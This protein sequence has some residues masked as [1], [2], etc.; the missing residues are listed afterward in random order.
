L[1]GESPPAIIAG[2]SCTRGA[3]SPLRESEVCRARLT[4][5]VN[6]AGFAAG[7]RQSVRASTL[8]SKPTKLNIARINM[9]YCKLKEADMPPI[10]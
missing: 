2:G 10:W 8:P 9:P 5:G 6:L 7:Y 3:G 1:R 4:P